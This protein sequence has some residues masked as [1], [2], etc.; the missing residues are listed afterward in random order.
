MMFKLTVKA[1]DNL[2]FSEPRWTGFL[3][4]PVVTDGHHDGY[5]YFT[6]PGTT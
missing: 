2:N 1:A 3:R 4:L 5:C 6:G